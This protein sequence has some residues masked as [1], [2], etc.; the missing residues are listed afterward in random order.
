MKERYMLPKL[1]NVHDIMSLF[2]KTAEEL[3]G[4]VHNVIIETGSKIEKIIAMSALHRTFANTIKAL[5]HAS[6]QLIMIGKIAWVLQNLSPDDAMRVATHQ[7][8]IDLQNFDIDMIS[9]NLQ[10]YKAVREYVEH[11]GKIEQLNDEEQRYLKDLIKKF[12]KNGLGLPEDKQN[13]VKGLKKEL[14]QISLEFHKN[15]NTDNRF[16]IISKAELAGLSSDFIAGLKKD[17]QGNYLLGVDYPTYFGVIENCSVETTRHALWREFVNRAYPAN[18]EILKKMIAVRDRLAKMLGFASYAALEIDDEMAK[19][20][21]RVQKF[22]EELNQKSASKAAVEF[23][24]WKQDL[25]TGVSLTEKGQFKPWDIAYVKAHYK[26]KHLSLD[27]EK[28]KAY[29]P[30]QKTIDSILSIYAQFLNLDFRQLPIEGLWHQDVCYSAVYDKKDDLI[31]HLLLD[32][33]PRSNKYSHACMDQVIATVRDAKEFTP[34]LIMVIANFPKPVSGQP[35]L[36]RFDD[37]HTFFHEFGHAIHGLLGTTEMAGYSGTNTTLDFVEIPSQ[38][39]EEWMYDR[40]ILRKLGVH[41]QTS[42]PLDDMTIDRILEI[43]K[44]DSGSFLQRQIMQ[45]LLSLSCFVEGE[46]KD[47]AM[48]NKTL[49]EKFF[50]NYIVFD[51]DNHFEA[52]FGHLEGYGSRYYCYQWSKVFALDMFSRIQQHGLL[53]PEIGKLY[54]ENVL[55]K[56]GSVDP[57]VLIENFLGRKSNMD[58]FVKELGLK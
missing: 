39:F 16:I 27:E 7:A 4:R 53:N 48:L 52:A 11:A 19:T 50:S 45:S 57:E 30:M 32:L 56:G 8:M 41:Y 36:M 2:P 13:V 49:S 54:S 58:A 22:L 29:F 28:L 21:E 31:G 44:F 42:D 37:V 35:A 33:H 26:K 23:A 25:P 14:T 20:P 38:M 10:L 9:N 18:E 1:K 40:D 5:D 46:H 51:A 6:A 15:I 24:T 55:G 34:A 12:E 3:S 47:P 43:K 17:E